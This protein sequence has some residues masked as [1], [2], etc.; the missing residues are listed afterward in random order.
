MP[1]HR[2]TEPAVATAVLSITSIS[3]TI[4]TTITI[5]MTIIITI[6]ITI[7]TIIITSITTII[8]ITN[9]KDRGKCMGMYHMAVTV[10]P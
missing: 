1:A 7:M 5:I 2:G 4:M 6:I 10:E 3:I 9:G 8:S